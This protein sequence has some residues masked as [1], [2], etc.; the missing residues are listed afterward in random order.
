MRRCKK[1]WLMHTGRMIQPLS[2][3]YVSCSLN[4]LQLDLIT[5]ASPLLPVKKVPCSPK[6]ANAGESLFRLATFHA[7]ASQLG[8][9]QM[10]R[11]SKKNLHQI[12]W[13]LRIFCLRS[14]VRQCCCFATSPSPSHTP[15]RSLTL[16]SIHRRSL[17]LSSTPHPPHTQQ[18]LCLSLPFF[19][20]E[21]KMYVY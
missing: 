8:I 7:V 9:P 15:F 19:S 13:D 20:L 16:T 5:E 4:T 2:C 3:R 18:S 17:S 14:S 10:N 11:V 1:N 6:E 21:M 12:S